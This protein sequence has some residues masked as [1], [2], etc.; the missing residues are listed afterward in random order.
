M[1][2]EWTVERALDPWLLTAIPELHHR[3][4]AA[5]RIGWRIATAMLHARRYPDAEPVAL[6]RVIPYG[7]LDGLLDDEHARFLR[8]LQAHPDA[9]APDRVLEE[10]LD[11][12][13]QVGPGLP[14]TDG[15]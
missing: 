15:T 10:R 8:Q 11:Y 4:R 14:V 12:L 2:T 7:D 6:S 9:T 1:D 3:P 5:A 13:R